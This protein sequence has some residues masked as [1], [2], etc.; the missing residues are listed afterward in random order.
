MTEGHR[1]L[2]V[3]PSRRLGVARG[4]PARVGPSDGDLPWRPA[5]GNR[6]YTRT[7]VW[8]S[9]LR[10]GRPPRHGCPPRRHRAW[11]HSRA[12]CRCRSARHAATRRR[13]LGRPRRRGDRRPAPHRRPD[14]QVDQRDRRC[15]RPGEMFRISQEH[16]LVL[17][18]RS[19][20]S[21]SSSCSSTASAARSTLTTTCLPMPPHF[22]K[23]H[24]RGGMTGG[25]HHVNDLHS[26][27]LLPELPE[28]PE[29]PKPPELSALPEL[30]EL[31][32]MPL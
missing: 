12:A 5:L 30:P 29:L 31:P 21:S 10:R 11:G 7:A 26:Y 22:S 8:C 1:R 23:P 20:A 3:D 18:T 17:P 2:G 28:P 32:E 19:W 25:A 13:G 27:Q 4:Q 16:H 6:S 14:V 9:S 24:S 15:G